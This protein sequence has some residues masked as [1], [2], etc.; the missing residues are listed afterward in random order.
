MKKNVKSTLAVAI[1]AALAAIGY[2]SYTQYQ[3]KQFAYANPLMEENIEALADD[4]TPSQEWYLHTFNNC[5]NLVVNAHV[6]AKALLIFNARVE[7]GAN[8]PVSNYT[9]YFNHIATDGQGP[10]EKGEQI[11]CNG[12]LQQ[13]TN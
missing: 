11:T 1:V 5:E 9:Q 3:D 10:C 2:V 4:G 12:V 7:I 8:F 6:K 13:L